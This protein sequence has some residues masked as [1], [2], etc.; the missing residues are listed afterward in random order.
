VQGRFIS[1]NIPFIHRTKQTSTESLLWLE[2]GRWIGKEQV[3]SRGSVKKNTA[4]PQNWVPEEDLICLNPKG[5]RR[6][7]VVW[8]G[9]NCQ[10]W[11]EEKGPRN[12]L[13]WQLG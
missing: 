9:Q 6:S 11:S 12:F 5:I 2:V 1:T 3:G 10:G 8:E 7:K 13:V 4:P